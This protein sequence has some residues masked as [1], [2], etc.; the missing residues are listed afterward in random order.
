MFLVTISILDIFC[1]VVVVLVQHTEGARGRVQLPDTVR[2]ADRLGAVAA[3]G[4]Q[5][6]GGA[7]LPAGYEA[8]RE[9]EVLNVLMQILCSWLTLS[10]E[11]L[12]NY[13][14]Y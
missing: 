5:E 13:Q 10:L 2:W 3:G 1:D 7:Q 11:K 8:G 6:V 14:N 12:T 9:G 4:P